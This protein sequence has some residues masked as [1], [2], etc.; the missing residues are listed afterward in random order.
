MRTALNN[1]HRRHAY[2]KAL[3]IPVWVNRES[4]P[5]PVSIESNKP[6]D[7]QH[8]VHPSVEQTVSDLLK[9]P[10]SET[11]KNDSPNVEADTFTLDTEKPECEGLELPALEQKILT[12]Q[13][14]TL[15]NSRHQA[16]P[17]NGNL[18]A[19][20]MLVGDAPCSESDRNNLSFAGNNAKLLSNMLKSIGLEAT[21]IYYTNIVK[22]RPPASRSA[23]T[24]ELQTCRTF[25]LRQIQ[26]LEIKFILILG[27]T[28]ANSLLQK[29]LT[30]A[31]LR[32]QVH[33][34]PEAEDVS[35]V[36]TYH[37]R[38]LLVQKAE[39]LKAWED[40]KLFQQLI[41]EKT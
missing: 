17:G 29:Q 21:D 12:C 7:E 32:G 16:I 5:R 37:P 18:K 11:D 10:P 28:S 36:V 9:E 34:I 3:G 13:S 15:Y 2:L 8:P 25:L 35:T 6:K 26:L 1:N 40:L 4:N 22:C 38:Y 27:K 14:C 30:I 19:K 31:K 41:R 20:I 39:K 24:R 23:S 33:T